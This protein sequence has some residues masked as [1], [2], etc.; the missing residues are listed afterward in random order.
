MKERKLPRRDLGRCWEVGT[1]TGQ[2][3]STTRSEKMSS[4]AV[5][6][7]STWLHAH[8]DTFPV[9]SHLP[10]AGAEGSSPKADA[11]CFPREGRS[12]PVSWQDWVTSGYFKADLLGWV[13]GHMRLS[14]W[15]WL[16]ASLSQELR[17]AAH[18]PLQQCP[19]PQTLVWSR[20]LAWGWLTLY[21]C[22]LF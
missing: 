6:L 11:N 15:L 21:I 20:N 18:L 4:K 13:L 3:I 14:A 17:L 12:L 19:V 8:L 22:F 9:P 10:W 5:P 16:T 1:V 7:P 2:S